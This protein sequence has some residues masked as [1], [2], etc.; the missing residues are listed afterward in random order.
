MSR[1]VVSWLISSSSLRLSVSAI[2]RALA[3]GVGDELVRLRLG[4]GHDLRGARLRL[5]DRFVGRLLRQ[6]ERALDDV[7]VGCAHGRCGGSHRRHGLR[8]GSRRGRCG[9]RSLGHAGAQLRALGLE[10]LDGRGR[11]LQQ[12]VDIVAVIA[13]PRLPDLDVAE[14]LRGDVHGRHGEPC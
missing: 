14:L 7:R 8:C 12:L 4:L 2:R 6:H 13:A 11:S 10:V 3:S 1:A 9:L 5:G